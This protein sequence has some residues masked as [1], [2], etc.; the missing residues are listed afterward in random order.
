[1][2]V[3]L[4]DKKEQTSA[5]ALVERLFGIIGPPETLHSDQSP[6][7]KNEVVKQLQDISSYNRT[8]TTPYRLQDN[9]VSERMN[10]IRHSML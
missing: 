2:F 7:F 9:S 3:S 8:R 1:M 10:S 6:E 5:K 4:P